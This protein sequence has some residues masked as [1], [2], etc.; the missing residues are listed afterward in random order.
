MKPY[1]L[2]YL[3]TKC[4]LKTDRGNVELF[5]DQMGDHRSWDLSKWIA[6]GFGT[7]YVHHIGDNV[8][9][10]VGS[11]IPHLPPATR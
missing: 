2:T 5:E 6:P 3:W 11:T 10:D 9:G 4:F 1:E 8:C 7:Y